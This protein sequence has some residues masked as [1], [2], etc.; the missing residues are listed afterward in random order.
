MI[1]WREEEMQRQ[2]GCQCAL[3][4]LDAVEAEGH[5]PGQLQLAY[6]YRVFG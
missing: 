3:D 6:V 1:R 2:F 5:R 4:C